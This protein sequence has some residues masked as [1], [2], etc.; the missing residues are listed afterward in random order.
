MNELA[1]LQQRTSIPAQYL[2]EPAPSNAELHEIVKAGIAAPDHA[3]LRPWRFIVVRGDARRQLGDVLEAAARA[4]EPDLN[5]NKLAR[6]R[7][8]PMRSPL[9]IT[10]VAR[11]TPN[12]PKSPEIEQV[13]S[14]GAAAQQMMLAANALGFGAI[15]LTGPN[16]DSSQVKAALGAKATDVIV[17]FLYMGTATIAAPKP[18]RPEVKDHLLF[19]QE[20]GG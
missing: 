7:D 16:A 6:I 18:A 4:R 15:W 20:S 10:V 12:H 8:K 5:E 13:L 9:I 14:A 11:I 2:S 19:W 1:F 17:G 3:A